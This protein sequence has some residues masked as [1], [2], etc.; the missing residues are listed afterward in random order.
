MVGRWWTVVS[1]GSRE[2]CNH[3]RRGQR[4]EIAVP[5]VKS[6]SGQYEGVIKGIEYPVNHMFLAGNVSD[7]LNPQS[8]E[9]TGSPMKAAVEGLVE[10]HLTKKSNIIERMLYLPFRFNSVA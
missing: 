9:L 7:R 2:L 3:T 1:A 6:G 4:S 5:F 8:L 10:N